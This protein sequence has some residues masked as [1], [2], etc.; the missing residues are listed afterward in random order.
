[1]SSFFEKTGNSI[2][3]GF[4]TFGSGFT[5]TGSEGIKFYFVLIILILA[6]TSLMT[7]TIYPKPCG[8]LNSASSM[9]E[10]TNCT[11][12]H[13]PS[14]D[15]TLLSRRDKYLTMY[16]TTIISLCVIFIFCCVLLY[17]ILNTGK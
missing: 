11:I 13:E 7:F 2:K 17:Y 5:R 14:E 12:L 16:I 4:F 1:M 6:F 8:E 9:S 10:M 15:G 3:N